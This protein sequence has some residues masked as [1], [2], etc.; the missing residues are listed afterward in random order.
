MMS[1]LDDDAPTAAGGPP[2][3]DDRGRSARGEFL[4]GTVLAGRYRIVSLLGR[5][6]MGEVYRADDLRLGQTV[7]LKFVSEQSQ[8]DSDYLRRLVTEARLARQVSHP[9]VCRVYDLGDADG[10]Q[11]ISMEYVDGEDLASLLTRI[12]HLPQTKALDIA[13]QLCAGLEAAHRQGVLHRD[14]KPS[15][16]ML[17]G[18]GHVRITDF[19]LAVATEPGAGSELRAGTPAYMAPEQLEGRSATVRSDLYAL[20]LVLYELFTGTRAF[21]AADLLELLRIGADSSPTPPS[22]LVDGFDPAIERAILSC[23]E[24]DPELRPA[25]ASAVSAALP[26][27]DAISAALAAGVTPSP[28]L[29]A[30]SGPDG[31]LSATRALTIAGITVVAL[32]A[33]LF[34][35][36]RAS[37]LGWIS[38]TRSPDVLEDHAR[39]II[40]RLGYDPAPVDREADLSFMLASY[41]RYVQRQDPSPDRWNVLRQPGQTANYF[42]YRHASRYLRPANLHGR[43]GFVDPPLEPGDIVMVTDL[44]GRL[45]YFQAIPA[46]ADPPIDSSPPFDWTLLFN[47]AGLDLARFQPTPPTRN[48]PVTTDVRAAW[49]GALADFATYPVRVEAAAHRG[50][51]V[52]FEL[53]VPWDSYWN[54]STQPGPPAPGKI[55]AALYFLVYLLGCGTAA[56]LVVRNIRNGRGDRRG[57]FRLAA[58][59]FALR[60]GIWI[61]GGHHVPSFWHELQMMVVALAKSLFDAAVTWCFYIALE[62]HARRLYPRL[63]ISWTRMLRGYARDPLVGRDLLY[64]AALS[65]IAIAF[66]AQLYV[67]IPHT[68]GMNDPPFP[69][70]TGIAAHPYAFFLDPPATKTMLGGRYVLEAVLDIALLALGLGMTFPVLLLGQLILLRKWWLNYAVTLAVSSLMVWPAQFSGFSAIGIA[71]TV[72]GVIAMLWA[73]RFGLVCFLALWFCVGVWMNFPVTTRVDAPHFGIGLVGVLIIAAVA[74]YG[75]FTAALPR[76]S[77]IPRQT[78]R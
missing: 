24:R 55:P 32:I 23:L 28:E 15:N 27:G 36:D 25:S 57:A 49:R 17:D 78:A 65:T 72:P 33:L 11:F 5:G 29:V 12:G 31:A 51:P 42:V 19:G 2:G 38:L 62:P 13:K 71:C 8:R 70:P 14:L 26:G 10:R 34:L 21:R 7:A 77:A 52:F 45:I 30:V 59:V 22:R 76:A 3:V 16:V 60:F 44:R 37:V 69:V 48:P 67:L 41:V 46:E 9:N 66:W 74:A 68:F 39:G 6:G 53:V 40:R 54:P 73:V 43:V 56:V 20:G 64:G 47:E 35:S 18:R 4:P 75:A 58:V 63:L 50:K 1:N 61:V